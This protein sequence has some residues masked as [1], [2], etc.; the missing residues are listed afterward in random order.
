VNRE[1]AEERLDRRWSE[2]QRLPLAVKEHEALCPV[3]VLALG[4]D[5][6]VPDAA[7]FPD[8]FQ[9]RPWAPRERRGA[10]SSVLAVVIGVGGPAEDARASSLEV[11]WE[12]YLYARPVCRSL[13]FEA[14]SH[15]PS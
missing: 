9:Q 3:N 1:V 13:S 5:A 4:A 8:A 14:R 11:K 15:K 2:L 7:G 12:P 6:A 10:G